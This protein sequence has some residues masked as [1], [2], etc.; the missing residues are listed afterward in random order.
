M[1]AEALAVAAYRLGDDR[2][3]VLERLGGALG[4]DARERSQQLSGD[5]RRQRAE[6]AARARVPV[7][8]GLRGVHATWIEAALAELPERARVVL[9]GGPGDVESAVKTFDSAPRPVPD[10]LA[11]MTTQVPKGI[12]VWLARWATA[13]L[14]PL[15]PERPGPPRTPADVAALPAGDALRWLT[16][17]A[18]DQLA[19]ALAGR[20]VP[21]GPELVQARARIAL[22]PRA[23]ALGPQR[24]ALERCIDLTP[25]DDES[26][27]IAGARTVAPH[28]PVLARRALALRLPRPLGLRVLEAFA[29]FA[30]LAGPSWIALAA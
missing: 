19:H 7:P 11:L 29:G 18:L 6:W 2:D 25:F 4:R 26:R 9:A 17:V 14:V 1:I 16:D 27:V 5:S 15:P 24:A 13:E 28:L 22:P 8:A 20:D 21:L 30:R 3:G 10:A 12:D 23:G